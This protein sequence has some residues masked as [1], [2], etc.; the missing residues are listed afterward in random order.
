LQ[1][2]D[3]PREEEGIIKYMKEK[4]D[5]NY[6]P[7]PEEVIDITKDNFEEIVSKQDI[8]LVEFFAPWCGHCKKLAPE[9]EK[10]ATKLKALDNPI[11]I[12]KVDATK[13]RDLAEKYGVQG[14]PDMRI[15]RK[16][17]QVKY[18]GP[19]EA[20]GITEYME[21]Q[22]GP[23]SREIHTLKGVKDF[24]KSNFDEPVILGVFQDEND[25][26]LKLY[27]EAN[28]ELRDDYSFGHTF[29]KEVKKLF[30]VEGSAIVVVHPVHLRSEYEP[31][32][33]IFKDAKA[34]ASDVQAFY[35]E[36]QVP[37]VGHYQSHTEKRFAKRPLVLVF[38]DVD[39]QNVEVRSMSQFW[40]N[41]VLSVAR[42]Y[43]DML[44]AVAEEAQFEEKLKKAGLDD[45]GEEVNVVIV[46]SNER[47][48]P[49]VDEEFSEDTLDDFIQSYLNGEVKP[50]VKS[51]IAPKKQGAVKTVVG[52]TFDEIV[53]DESKEV[54]IEFYAPWCGHCKALEPDYKK[55]AEKHKGK[56]NLVIAKLDA[57]AN[58]Y[59]PHFS[60][61]GFP[62]IY[63]APP[64]KKNTP[65]LF[66]GQRTVEGFDKF[67]GEHSQYV[68]PPEDGTDEEVKDAGT[69]KKDE[70]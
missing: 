43:P 21:R 52:S 23:P 38:Y 34:A 60:V 11:L 61:S 40:R 1:D 49:M 50:V 20:E 31:K 69:E 12:G 63:W 54:L 19:R 14:Y 27:Y 48:Y 41:K 2:Y 62:T 68:T 22:A 37:L 36:H 8:M 70:L 7:P 25:P 26:M 65:V 4:S 5:P 53:M 10:A 35:K 30:G 67:L 13:E 58:D 46:D 42:K 33:R 24:M 59:P 44:F 51:Q 3:G 55:L 15:F 29:E 18:N 39:F 57:T 9:L 6:K 16:G 66:D 47:H 28:Q 17:E 45:S 64:G 32:Y 56:K